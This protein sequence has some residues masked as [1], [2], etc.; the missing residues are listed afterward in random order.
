MGIITKFGYLQAKINMK[1]FKENTK[2]YQVLTPDGFQNFNGI[3]L[4]GDC[5]ILKLT[6]GDL[7]IECTHDHKIYINNAEKIEA[8][9]I[10]IGD[11]VT[12]SFGL[13]ELT[14]IEEKNNEAVYD[15]IGVDSGN[16]FYANDIL[17]SNCVFLIYDETLINAMRL[18]ELTGMQPLTIMG[19]SRWYQVPE[20]G[21][22]YSASLDP[23][24]GTG[25]DNAAIQIMDLTTMTQVAE[26]CH[27]KTPIEGQ[28]QTLMGMLNYLS[29]HGVQDIY[30]SVENNSIGEA[31]LVVIRDTGEES[32]PGEF[33]SEPKKVTGKKGRRGF[34]TS[35]RSKMEACLSLKRYIEQK[36]IVINS[37]P[38]ISELKTFVKTA[39]SFAAKESAM[40]DLVM[41]LVLNIRMIDYISTFEEGV[42]D[43]VNS[44]LGLNILRNNDD[45]DSDN[46]EWSSPMPIL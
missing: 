45:Y 29:E 24:A 33:L 41:S 17:V 27:N 26:W 8:Q 14:L 12:T 13:K 3:A 30:W 15:L 34:H 21:H 5:P 35:N 9:N 19:N 28:I 39:H 38:L 4:M 36:K 42:Y 1:S 25:G 23:S 10:K 16:R 31:A 6:F 46:D 20:A 32:F 44:S 40:D 18:L 7:W 37:V 11:S 22:I 43:S 2:K